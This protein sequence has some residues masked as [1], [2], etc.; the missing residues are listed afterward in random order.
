MDKKLVSKLVFVFLALVLA[1]QLAGCASP[2]PPPHR[3]APANRPTNTQAADASGATQPKGGLPAGGAGG[4]G[5]AMTS[6]TPAFKDVVYAS[7]SSAQ[8]LDLY[9]PSGSGLFPLVIMIHGGG[10][11]M[12]INRMAAGYPV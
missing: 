8:K 7:T 4:M 5:G 11:L 6:L 10:F 2:T 1:I 12:G 9:L 3:I